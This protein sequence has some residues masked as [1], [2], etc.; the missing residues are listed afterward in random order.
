MTIFDW[1]GPSFGIG[2]RGRKLLKNGEQTTARVVGI[3]VT[4]ISIGDGSNDRHYAYALD[5]QDRIGATERLGCR[6]FVNP[7]R[8]LVGLGSQVEV[9]RKGDDV[10]I[11]WAATLAK[12]GATDEHRMGDSPDFWKPLGKKAPPEGVDDVEQRS[13]QKRIASGRAARA[14]ILRIATPAGGLFGGSVENRDLD[15]PLPPTATDRVAG[16]VGGLIGK[17]LASAGMP[18]EAPD[19]ADID[20]DT[21]V[22]VSAGLARDGIAPEDAD[23]YASRHGWAAA[24]QAWQVRMAKNWKLGAKYGS[25]YAAAYQRGPGGGSGM[26]AG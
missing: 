14:T 19:G 17:A 23:A 21:F 22:T 5:V 11:D 15:A 6:Q 4:R 7:N 1:D 20:F 18:D 10:I 12:L 24:S 9:R 13:D 8:K 3:T 26:S 16:A 2:R 25:A